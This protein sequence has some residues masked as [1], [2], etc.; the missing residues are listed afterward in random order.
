VGDEVRASYQFN[1]EGEKVLRGLEVIQDSASR[2]KKTK[3][4]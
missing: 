2:S 1:E 4:K 3:R